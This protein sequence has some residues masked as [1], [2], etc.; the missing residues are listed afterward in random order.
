MEVWVM[1]PLWCVVTAVF[2][3]ATSV[4]LLDAAWQCCLWCCIGPVSCFIRQYTKV[5]ASLIKGPLRPLN[6]DFRQSAS[7]YAVRAG[8][9]C[10][11]C[12]CHNLRVRNRKLFSTSKMKWYKTRKKI[13]ILSSVLMA[14]SCLVLEQKSLMLQSSL[15]CIHQLRDS[16]V[17]HSLPRTERR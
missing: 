8:T 9:L 13:L 10:D 1:A 16:R 7:A 6:N 12:C 15:G 5:V 3:L 14:L 4:L 2:F 11:K 17:S